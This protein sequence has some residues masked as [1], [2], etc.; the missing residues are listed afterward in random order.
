MDQHVIS[1]RRGHVL[2]IRLDRPEKKNAITNAMYGALTAAFEAAEQDPEVRVLL[3]SGAGDAFTAGNDLG[4]FLAF[5]GAGGEP[6][7]VPFIRRLARFAKPIVAAVH[8]AAVGIGTTL[9]LHCDIVVAARSTRLQLPFVSLGLVP[10]AASSLL[11]PR[12]AGQQRASELLLLGEP[13]DAEQALQLGLVNRVVGDDALMETG[14]ALADR[15]AALPP[16]AVRETRA[17]LRNDAVGVPERIEAELT[18]FSRRLASPEFREAATAFFE[19]RTP[20]F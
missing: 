15:L 11:L 17:L 20:R 3:L 8:G 12:L 9:L 6:G 2:E 13:F 18:V 7:G 19:K 1:E 5:A 10:E 14:R 16:E 4:D